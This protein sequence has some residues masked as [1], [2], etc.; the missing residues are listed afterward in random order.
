MLGLYVIDPVSGVE[1]WGKL[2]LPRKYYRFFAKDKKTYIAQAELVVA[3]AVWYTLPKLLRGRAVMHFVDNTVA[4][5]AIVKGNAST[6]DC[7]ALVNCFHAAIVELRSYL[8]SEWVPSEANPADWPTRPDKEH[9]IPA[10]AKRVSIVLPPME[11]WAA[12]LT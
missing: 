12:M 1:Y 10:S 11:E 3:V 9:L 4:L 7:A 2:L 8:W 6:C 5:S